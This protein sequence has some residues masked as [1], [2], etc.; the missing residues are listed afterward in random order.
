MGSEIYDKHS[1][2]FGK[3]WRGVRELGTVSR[4]GLRKEPWVMYGKEES[5]L[6]LSQMYLPT[7]RTVSVQRTWRKPPGAME[8]WAG[9]LEEQGHSP[10]PTHQTRERQ[11]P[12]PGHH[13]WGKE[14]N[15]LIH[16]HCFINPHQN[17]L[18][19]SVT[20]SYKHLGGGLGAMG[21]T[22]SL[23]PWLSCNNATAQRKR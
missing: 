8:P 20:W 5:T 21:H 13:R 4:A 12:H 10:R 15:H 9:G 16:A 23:L 22:A 3:S 14:G 7:M 11:R 2:N 17:C 6:F 1:E 19:W 18:L